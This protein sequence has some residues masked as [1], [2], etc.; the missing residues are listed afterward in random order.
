MIV[1]SLSALALSVRSTLTWG[2]S[3]P[4]TSAPAPAREKSAPARPT[5]TVEL[6]KDRAETLIKALDA[7]GDGI[8]TKEE[9]TDGAIEL[10]KR[11]SVRFHHEKVGKGHG[12]EKRDDR[13]TTRLEDVFAHV[14]ANRDG[15]IDVNELTSALPKPVQRPAQRQSCS[16]T[17]TATGS[18]APSAC[19]GE[20]EQP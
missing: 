3:T 15:A 14:D 4:G 16:P 5:D 9:F 6:S 1:T 8:V 7:D 19:A 17:Q 2:R 12:I 10:L 18:P 11:A 13:W 20:G